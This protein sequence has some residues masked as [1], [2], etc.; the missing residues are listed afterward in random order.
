MGFPPAKLRRRKFILLHH[1]YNITSLSSCQVP[2][3]L[4]FCYKSITAPISRPHLILQCSA[5]PI[6]KSAGPVYSIHT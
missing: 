3:L 6:D 1:Y 5:A 4:H 2:K